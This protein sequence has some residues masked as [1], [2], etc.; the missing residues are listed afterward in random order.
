MLMAVMEAQQWCDKPENH[1]E[2]ARIMSKRQWI[3]APYED[4]IDRTKGKF[5]YGIP[6][7]VVENS[8]HI[9]KYWMN[10]ASY[11]FQSHDLW[12]IT[13]DIRWAKFE[14]TVDAKGLI[15]KVNRED[16]WRESAKMLGVKPSDIPTSTSRGKETFFDGKVFDPENP[17]AY[18]KSLAIKRAEIG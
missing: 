5:N 17:A 7:K 1:E 6:D 3:N 12:F 2:L 16:I 10:H 18:L 11:P 15:R 9:M 4:I 14:A 13:E 8:P